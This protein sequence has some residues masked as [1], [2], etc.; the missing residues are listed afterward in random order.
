[1]K[2]SYR[3]LRP[4]SLWLVMCFALIPA[5]RAESKV[6]GYTFED[7]NPT[8]YSPGI[9][10]LP[11]GAAGGLT[12]EITDEWDY[13]TDPVLRI[14]SIAARETVGDAIDKGV[15]FDFGVEISDPAY[16]S[17]LHGT[18][19]SFDAARGG[20][21]EPRGFGLASSV[22]G[23]AT[24]T[25]LVSDDIP[26][27]RNT[28]T[29]Y[30]VPLI[31]PMFSNVTDDVVFR[32]Y[33]YSPSSGSSIEFDNIL[34]ESPG[35]G[36]WI[37]VGAD[38][39][40][41]T[42]ANWAT[43]SAPPSDS[44]TTITL[45]NTEH[46]ASVQDAADPFVLN[47]LNVTG[48]GDGV[49]VSGNPLRF[50]ADGNVG[51]VLYNG[52]VAS[53]TISSRVE[54]ASD[55]TAQIDTGNV[56]LSGGI[57]GAGQIMYKRGMGTLTLA[58]EVT[59]HEI[60]LATGVLAVDSGVTLNVSQEID[61]RRSGGDITFRSADSNP[62]TVGTPDDPI[63]INLSSNVALG[64]TDTGDL[65]FH[66][67]LRGGGAAKVVTINN[68]TT[69]FYGRV[70]GSGAAITKQGS[71]TL[72]F[73]NTS[74]S[75]PLIINEGTLQIGDG[76]NVGTLGNVAV[77]NNSAI[78]VDRSGSVTFS[79]AISGTGTLTTIGSGTLV[80][81]GDNTY[82]GGTTVEN[83][84]LAIK[85]DGSLG[86]VP[87][88][89][90]ADNVTLNGGTLKNHGDSVELHSNRGISIGS[91]GGTVEVDGN[92][93]LTVLG[94]I[95][96]AGNDLTKTGSGTLLLGP[97]T[98]TLRQLELAAGELAV[99]ADA[100][101]STSGGSYLDFRRD[102]GQAITF[103][104]ADERSVTITSRV[105]LATDV[106]LGSDETG[107]LIFTGQLDPGGGAKTIIVNNDTT[108]FRGAITGAS[109]PIT[110]AGPGTLVFANISYD[111]KPIVI[112]QGTL[113]V[114]E[115][116]ENGTLGDV[117]VTNNAALVVNRT[118]ELV[119]TGAISGNGTL[120]QAGPGTL[121]LTGN[122]S[123]SGGTTVTGGVLRGDTGSLRGS[124]LN[125]ATV[126][127]DQT[128]SGSYSGALSGTG[129]L[130]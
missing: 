110:K 18:V 50:E 60:E 41:S 89:F 101:I 96:G 39:H 127:F 83:G 66:G 37:G 51:P 126:V 119:I 125:N 85:A 121:T 29:H 63:L 15:Y 17:V 73:V 81:T 21:T 97:E 108:T 103:R 10:G 43:G 100:T 49:S 76:G 8:V 2:P 82:Q 112:S 44:T 57:D 64:S 27:A 33:V 106:T 35:E 3:W 58:G 123:Y 120:T 128:S 116:G 87:G 7:L 56:T 22:D 68:E 16:S 117:N 90:L 102:G 71:G 95:A 115:G 91:Q 6:I 48:V 34:I 52:R 86:A 25:M 40:W 53:S 42:A 38:N 74:I 77:E 36:Y 107:D 69:A 114:G 62:L 122:N 19:L 24:W 55:L 11:V 129:V 54:L 13:P 4:F 98:F 26:T 78:V 23:F 130:V 67:E 5:Y 99:D 109:S 45:G 94:A 1:M 92:T 93:T 118:G 65:V 30:S 72:V 111:S 31:D 124:I 80:L 113:Q 9:N 28:F 88:S 70:T 75:K 14:L 46:I 61:F 47:R 84:T 105:N 12:L 59:L 79:G 20:S 32:I 104:S